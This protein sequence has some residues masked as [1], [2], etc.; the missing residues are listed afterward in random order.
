MLFYDSNENVTPILLKL[1]FKNVNDV[2]PYLPTTQ[3]SG[4]TPGAHY[5]FKAINSILSVSGPSLPSLD[6]KEATARPGA[7]EPEDVPATVRPSRIQ[8]KNWQTF[9]EK[10]TVDS[11]EREKQRLVSTYI[12]RKKLLPPTPTPAEA[13]EPINITAVQ[14][15]SAGDNLWKA[16]DCRR[17]DSEEEVAN[18]AG[19]CCGLDMKCHPKA[20]VSTGGTM[21]RCP[22]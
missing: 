13:G 14:L 20:D 5:T 3:L 18:M 21:E 22:D 11:C 1:T 9:S 6:R 17:G 10:N 7:T 2:V 8:N 15:P 12:T 4:P 19:I 16:P